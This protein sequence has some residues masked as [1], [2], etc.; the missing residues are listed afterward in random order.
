L[1]NN[2]GLFLIEL[3]VSMAIFLIFTVL[4][5]TTFTYQNKN[6][7]KESDIIAS[8]QEGKAVMSILTN[9]I[10][11][12]GY[13]HK[14]G[15]S[16]NGYAKKLNCHDVDP[17]LGSDNVTVVAAIKKVAVVLDNVSG[18]ATVNVKQVVQN[19]LDNSTKRYVFFENSDENECYNIT[20]IDNSVSGSSTLTLDRNVTYAFSNEPVYL[21][22]AYTISV[23]N[24]VLTIYEN[25]GGGADNVSDEIIENLQ[26]QYG[27]DADKSGAIESTE[28]VDN[29]SGS[30]DKI[31]AVKIFLL[32]RSKRRDMSYTDKTSYTLA[33]KSFVP[34]NHYHHYLMQSII[35][36]RN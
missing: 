5:Y 15:Q 14:S 18:S 26:L 22:K 24:N 32:L 9:I 13:G 23:V 19:G 7:I 21:V 4:L 35:Y 27:W 36:V 30:E 28:W 12:A 33:G 20:G 29:P 1:N 31:K 6:Y 25:T 11:M 17:S 8:Q 34:N 10:R 3:L 16:V 2:K